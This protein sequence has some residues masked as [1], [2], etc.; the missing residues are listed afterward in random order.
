MGD[1]DPFYQNPADGKPLVPKPRRVVG[2]RKR[3]T[4]A[5]LEFARKQALALHAKGYSSK[6]IARGLSAV[7]I[8]ATPEMVEAWL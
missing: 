6:Q 7:G 2:P 1:P 8:T 4:P 5:E 3:A